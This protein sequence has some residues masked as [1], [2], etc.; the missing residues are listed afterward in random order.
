[1]QWQEEYFFVCCSKQKH[2]HQIF[3]LMA[4]SD[5]LQVKI[6]KKKLKAVGGLNLSM[7]AEMS[8][9]SKK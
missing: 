2:T 5:K 1:V 6:I 4:S 8:V 7:L 3:H 9:K